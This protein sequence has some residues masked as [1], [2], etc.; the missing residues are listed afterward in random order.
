[1]EKFMKIKWILFLFVFICLGCQMAFQ[2]S[3]KNPFSNGNNSD[4]GKLKLILALEE[5]SKVTFSESGYSEDDKAKLLKIIEN[6]ENPRDILTLALMCRSLEYQCT[7]VVCFKESK[8]RSVF[9]NTY[10]LLVEKLAFDK[11]KNLNELKELKEKSY[12][13][14]GSL[15]N[16]GHIVEGKEL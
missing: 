8:L 15:Y 5:L 4:K 16:W 10:W 1:M 14:G 2:T 12:L 9:E 13:D 6:F 7:D 3:Q 11:E